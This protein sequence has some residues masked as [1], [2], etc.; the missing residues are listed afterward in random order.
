MIPSPSPDETAAAS[1]PGDFDL[2]ALLPDGWRSVLS[3]ALSTPSFKSLSAFLAKEYATKTVFPPREDLF[4]AFHLTPFDSVRVVILGQD[5]YH[6][7]GQAH[8]LAFSVR[9]GIRFPPSLRNIFQ[10]LAAD[11]GAPIPAE[12]SLI[13]WA[14]QG[15]LLLNTVLTVRAHAAASH[16]NRGWEEFTDHV[17]HVLNER[18]KPVI[19]VLWGSPAQKKESLIDP[20]KHFVICS[21]HP[22]PLS[23]HRGFFG[24]RPF[25]RINEQ[26]KRNGTP[27]I[28][29]RL[30]SEGR[31]F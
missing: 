31:L 14:K 11:T 6:D 19:F 2:A 30:P 15:V 17:I 18:K 1:P 22:S 12:G 29:W 21:P 28:D 27:A 5:P 26:L 23:A 9:P 13:P 24:S 3:D 8:G 25:S 4:S 20:Q 10:E 7:E 16:R